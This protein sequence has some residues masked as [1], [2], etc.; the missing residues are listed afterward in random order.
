MTLQEVKFRK[1]RSQ[2][3]ARELSYP[4][5][6]ECASGGVVG[7]EYE[8]EIG[9]EV[10]RGGSAEDREAQHQKAVGVQDKKQQARRRAFWKF[11]DPRVYKKS[12]SHRATVLFW[13]CLLALSLL[14]ASAV[15]VSIRKGGVSTFPLSRDD[16]LVKV[17]F[18]MHEEEHQRN[19][20][21]VKKAPIF[22][23][24]EDDLD[25]DYGGIERSKVGIMQPDDSN[26]MYAKY[27]SGFLH[28]IDKEQIPKRYHN[29]ED[30]E[31]E[32]RACRGPKWNSYIF[33][34]CNLAHE[35][36]IERVLDSGKEQDYNVTYLRYSICFHLGTHWF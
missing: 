14:L 4:E 6:F 12:S 23:V 3:A 25:P 13:V 32:K 20:V 28:A 9:C 35:H 16:S 24:Y 10:V 18:A 17:I 15:V 5:G 27:R 8:Y 26:S 7:G 1:H 31:D 34:T 30:R 36:T 19:L 21:S 11:C 29:D 2:S 22:D 33:P